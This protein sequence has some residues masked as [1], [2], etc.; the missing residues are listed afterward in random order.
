MG[1]A[2]VTGAYADIYGASWVSHLRHALASDCVALGLEDLDDSVLQQGEPRRL[3][4][5]A[6]LQWTDCNMPAIHSSKLSFASVTVC[7]STP[8]ADLAGI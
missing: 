1:E 3:T 4:Q 5:L 6:S 2:A 8:A 7:P